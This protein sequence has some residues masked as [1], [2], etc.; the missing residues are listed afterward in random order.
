MERIKIITGLNGMALLVQSSKFK[1][2]S[3]KFKVQSSK[4]I[5]NPKILN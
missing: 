2:Q 1:V 3:S 4:Q 5:S